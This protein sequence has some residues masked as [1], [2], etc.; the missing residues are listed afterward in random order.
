LNISR[1]ILCISLKL[2]KVL[3]I[4]LYSNSVSLTHFVT[5]YGSTIY[6][7]TVQFQSC[8]LYVNKIGVFGCFFLKWRV[9]S[10]WLVLKFT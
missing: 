9:G 5:F 10:R 4:K 8:I 2:L 7:D 6:P 1:Q 3:D